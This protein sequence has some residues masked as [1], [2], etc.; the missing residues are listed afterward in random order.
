MNATRS[1]AF[2]DRQ[3]AR[4]VRD[5]D[6]ELNPF[7]QMALPHLRGRLLD[8]G[9]GMGN[10]AVEAARRGCS[11]MAAD[12]SGAAI[13]HLQRIVAEQD[14]ALQPVLADLRQFDIGEDFDT[15]VSIG[16]LMF[17]DCPR[18]LRSLA[19]IRAH[20]K[21]GGTAIV[22]VLVQGTTFTDMFDPGEH[23]VFSRGALERSFSGWEIVASASKEFA[24]PDGRIKAFETVI[25]RNRDVTRLPTAQAQ[26]QDTQPL[27][28]PDPLAGESKASRSLDA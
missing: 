13:E 20:V 18:A 10:L 14:L 28:D 25:A 1:V 8:L 15:I 22:N 9:C 2:F 26:R 19:A 16:L 24:A 11:V 17:F 3:F 7:E 5:C 4:Q 27:A 6:F 21:P 23:C 12:A